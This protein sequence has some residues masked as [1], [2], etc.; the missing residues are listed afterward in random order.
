MFYVRLIST[1]ISLEDATTR[2]N[3]ANEVRLAAATTYKERPAIE[4]T[5]RPNVSNSRMKTVIEKA[6]KPHSVR[7][8][9]RPDD[10]PIKSG[11]ARR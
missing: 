5:P 2:L 6:M 8:W 11:R 9:K 1:D 10:P 4:I 3:A 7:I